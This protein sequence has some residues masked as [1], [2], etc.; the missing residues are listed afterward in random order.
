MNKKQQKQLE[1]ID[2]L[3]KQKRPPLATPHQK[4]AYENG[5]LKGLLSRIA[6]E[7][8]MVEK[9]IKNRLND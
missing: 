9:E 5:Y 4:L 8:W 3:L 2:L 6:S 7:Y 1:L